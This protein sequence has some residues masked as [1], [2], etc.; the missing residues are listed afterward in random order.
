MSFSRLSLDIKPSLQYTMSRQAIGSVRRLSDSVMGKNIT[1]QM[2]F[3]AL[4]AQKS[5]EALRRAIVVG[6]RVEGSA[7]SPLS[8]Y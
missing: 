8:R 6:R 4:E 5:Q 1:R 7:L 3:H 2:S